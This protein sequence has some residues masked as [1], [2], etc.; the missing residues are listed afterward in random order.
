MHILT[1]E[2]K[3]N[4]SSPHPRRGDKKTPRDTSWHLVIEEVT[5]RHLIPEEVKGKHLITIEE[6]TK[7]HLEPR[8]VSY[9]HLFLAP[10]WHPYEV[11]GVKSPHT[12]FSNAWAP[13]M[14]QIKGEKWH[15]R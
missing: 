11:N 4:T 8:R 9:F 12:V 3:K 1:E 15:L 2:V 14:A 10:V 13:L 7:K 6:V 5:K